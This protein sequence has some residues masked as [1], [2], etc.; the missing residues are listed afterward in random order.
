MGTP[1]KP[2]T[3]GTTRRLKATQ[4]SQASDLKATDQ[5]AT[6]LEASANYKSKP[7]NPNMEADGKMYHCSCC[8]QKFN[9]TN[10]A[11][12][13]PLRNICRMS[14]HSQRVTE[15]EEKMGSVLHSRDQAMNVQ[16]QQ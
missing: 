13:C 15:M 12:F 7:H 2:T 6:D 5:Q 16:L 1:E 4:D 3:R 9:K 11:R 14:S 8:K 10:L